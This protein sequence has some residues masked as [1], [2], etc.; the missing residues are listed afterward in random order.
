MTHTVGRLTEKPRVLLKKRPE[1]W[2]P[3][4]E[5]TGGWGAGSLGAAASCAPSAFAS[6][7]RTG[8]GRA[9][10]HPFLLHAELSEN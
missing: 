2:G 6:S 5:V 9:R 4:G 10:R 1:A 7:V 8:L 3:R